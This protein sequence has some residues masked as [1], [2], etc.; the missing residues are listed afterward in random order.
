MFSND[1]QGLLQRVNAMA[2][3]EYFLA[4]VV[5]LYLLRV[6][7][8]RGTLLG[9]SLQLVNYNDV[10]ARRILELSSA[11]QNLVCLVSYIGRKGLRFFLILLAL[12]SVIDLCIFLRAAAPLLLDGY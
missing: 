2:V 8:C 10:L 11:T 5:E 4:N 7:E 12:L 6:I 9:L 3:I 1:R